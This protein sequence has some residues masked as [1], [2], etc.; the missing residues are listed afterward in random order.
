MKHFEAMNAQQFTAATKYYTGG[1]A[2]AELNKFWKY[3]ANAF[4]RYVVSGR[5]D[6]LNNVAIA[7][8]ATGRYRSFVRVTKSLC[9]HK[10][11]GEKRQ[12]I[13]KADKK[14]LKSLRK[15]DAEGVAKWEQML[16]DNLLKEQEHVQKQPAKAW[17][18]DAV[19][20]NFVKNLA[21]HG[22]SADSKAVMEKIEAA[23]KKTEVKAAKAA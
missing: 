18:E 8:M 13:G 21:N 22:I 17:D 10:W 6:T 2:E 9:A 5:V 7:S 4:D 20:L 19:I 15:E 11:D 16:H 23:A 3:V 14:K 12:F 1:K